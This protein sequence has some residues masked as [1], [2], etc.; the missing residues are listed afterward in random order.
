MTSTVASRWGPRLGAAPGARTDVDYSNSLVLWTLPSLTS[1]DL[2][3]M[4]HGPVP[5]HTFVGHSDVVLDFDW[6]RSGNGGGED[7]DD[8]WIVSWSKD[9]T[10]RCVF[11]QWNHLPFKLFPMFILMLI[12]IYMLMCILIIICMFLSMFISIFIFKFIFIFP[13]MLC[14]CLNSFSCLISYLCLYS[15][16]ISYLCLYSCS[17]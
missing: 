11:E 3:M 8:C 4:D 1:N 14:L 16:L 13:H 9:N 12:F 5:V 6:K 17:Y 2:P 10:L 15:C 7:G